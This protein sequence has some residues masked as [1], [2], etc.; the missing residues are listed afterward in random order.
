MIFIFGAGRSGTTWL[1]KIFDSHPDVLYRHEPD[2][3]HRN[4]T[5]PV[6]VAPGDM[7]RWVP[8]VSSYIDLL[9]ATREVRAAGSL[10]MFAKSYRGPLGRIAVTGCAYAMKALQ[11]PLGSVGAI[12]RAKVP[13]LV[14]AAKRQRVRMVMKS[15]NSMGRAALFGRARPDARIVLI[16]RHPCGV[17]SSRLRGVRL[18][19][20]GGETHAEEIAATPEA[21]RYGV[22]SETLRAMSV[23]EQLAV[24]WMVHNE[25]TMTSLDGNAGARVVIYEDLCQ[26]PHVV[27]EDLFR[28][29][30][31]DF[32]GQTRTFIQR[33]LDHKGG[34]ETY[35]QTV[36]SP[37]KAA[38]KWHSEL[39][40]DQKRRIMAVTAPSRP[41]RL[42]ADAATE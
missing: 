24:F 33:C 41:G 23:E 11:L 17:V 15:V 30:G 13:D 21:Q 19:K 16:V 9:M 39:S 10:P 5:I 20:M 3:V 7:D 18:G 36:R 22:T 8:E 14:S 28:F 25:R 40:A 42:F 4:A 29:C 12:A 27:A 34:K 32:G 26:R 37:M 2:M 31:L 6:Y 38:F 1:G 35:F